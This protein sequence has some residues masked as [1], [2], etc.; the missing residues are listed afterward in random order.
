MRVLLLALGLTLPLLA[1]AA[2]APYYQ[3]QS[4]IDGTIICRQSSPGHG[5]ERLSGQPFRDLNCTMPAS[6]TERP[7]AIPGFRPQPGR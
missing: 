1:A 6:R 7:S 3:W 5:W 4:K 2:P